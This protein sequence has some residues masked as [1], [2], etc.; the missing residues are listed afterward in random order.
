MP[1]RGRVI[2]VPTPASTRAPKG[3]ARSPWEFTVDFDAS[4]DA[5]NTKTSMTIGTDAQRCH[6]TEPSHNISG[7]LSVDIFYTESL[8]SQTDY[9]RLL[10]L[11]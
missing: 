10:I 4:V 8:G 9:T 5:W 1:R 11:C 6:E 7:T 2:L 3:A